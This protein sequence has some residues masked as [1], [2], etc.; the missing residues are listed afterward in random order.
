[1]IKLVVFL[2]NPGPTYERT[3]HNLAWMLAEHLSF[4]P[5]LSWRRKFKGQFAQERVGE[6]GYAFLKPDTFMNK[7]GDSVR[8]L[9]DFFRFA[10]EE[11]LAVHDDLELGFAR[12]GF[13]RGGGLGGHNGLRSL[14]RVLGTPDFCRFRLAVLPR[15]L[16]LAARLLEERLEAGGFEP[17][18]GPGSTVNLFDWPRP[19]V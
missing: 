6:G 14:E 4:Y 13:K 1:M 9:L 11:L 3:R 16:E 7:S 10:P 18:P 8:L 15:Y 19:R 17:D 12:V 5:R 2:G